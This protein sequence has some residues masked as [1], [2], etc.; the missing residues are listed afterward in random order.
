MLRSLV[1]CAMLLLAGGQGGAVRD[2]DGQ[3]MDVLKPAQGTGRINVLLFVSSD[4]PI[5]NGYA[6]ALQKI[7]SAY[8]RQGVACSLFYEDAAI[9]PA[10][11]RAHLKEFGYSGIPA[12]IDAG[13]SVARQVKATVTPQAVVID[14]SGRVRYRG[15]IDNRYLDLGKPRRVV[16]AHDL[17]A[18]LDAVLA[19]RAV[20]TPDTPAV[21]CYI[22]SR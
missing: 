7:C 9:E 3:P 18:A 12:A 21:G 17:E 15:R 11:V 6:P 5:S 4:C 13:A 8:A 19:G 14:A 2:V 10:A 1:F 22:A 20:A 16:T